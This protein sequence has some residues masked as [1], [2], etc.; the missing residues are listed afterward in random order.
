MSTGPRDSSQVSSVDGE[1][2]DRTGSVLLSL[3]L[4]G[5]R[6]CWEGQYTG[7]GGRRIQTRTHTFP[8]V[9]NLTVGVGERPVETGFGDGPVWALSTSTV[10][11]KE[12]PSHP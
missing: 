6:D 8:G 12:V 2:S 9:S 5:P 11:T 7:S 10:K 1:K 4:K 3:F